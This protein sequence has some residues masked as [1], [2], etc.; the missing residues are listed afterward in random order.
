MF[1]W[2]LNLI[3][4]VEDHDTITLKT[5]RC[6]QPED[7]ENVYT[8]SELQNIIK[9]IGEVEYLSFWLNGS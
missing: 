5:L 4:F 9:M 1:E 6:L 8:S 7:E 2:I 3:G